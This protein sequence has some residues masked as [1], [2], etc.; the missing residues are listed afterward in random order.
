M[1]WKLMLVGLSA[2]GAL[3]VV[4]AD[5]TNTSTNESTIQESSSNETAAAVEDEKKSDNKSNC[6]CT[7]R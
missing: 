5:D 3:S 7:K 6:S 2:M 1:N 4:Q